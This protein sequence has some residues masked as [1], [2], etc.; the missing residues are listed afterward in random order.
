MLVW[1]ILGLEILLWTFL[2]C[3][4]QFSL[5]LV[6]LVTEPRVGVICRLKRGTGAQVWLDIGWIYFGLVNSF[7]D[8]SGLCPVI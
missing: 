7:M 3:L 5:L 8:F 2:E 4:L 1:F 6:S